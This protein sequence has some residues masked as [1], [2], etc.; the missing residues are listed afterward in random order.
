MTYLIDREG[1]IRHIFSSQF[2]AA[3]QISEALRVL[4]MLRGEPGARNRDGN[5]GVA[6]SPA[7]SPWHMVRLAEMCRA[8]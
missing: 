8:A 5:Q 1:V 3:R 7:R 2:Q 4:Q 6:G